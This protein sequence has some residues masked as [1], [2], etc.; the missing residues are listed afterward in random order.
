MCYHPL[1]LVSQQ[2]I[3][4]SS[5]GFDLGSDEGTFGTSASTQQLSGYVTKEIEGKLPKAGLSSRW[6]LL[7]L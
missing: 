1:L 2:G 7:Q 6:G 4:H 5:D 3:S